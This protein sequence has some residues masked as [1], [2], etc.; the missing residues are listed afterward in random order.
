MVACE[1]KASWFDVV[2]FVLMVV[3]LGFLITGSIR[4]SKII[5]Q[6][7]AERENSAPIEQ[8]FNNRLECVTMNSDGTTTFYY[9]S[10]KEECEHE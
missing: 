4:T 5:D 3:V 1:E 10:L 6:L 8:A 9:D 7:E 2:M